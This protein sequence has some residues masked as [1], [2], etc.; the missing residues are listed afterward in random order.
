M[1]GAMPTV[2]TRAIARAM[3]K[4]PYLWPTVQ[5]ELWLKLPLA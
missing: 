5:L 3:D 4:E 1:A 2:L